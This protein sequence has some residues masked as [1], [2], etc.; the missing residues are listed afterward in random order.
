MYEL[1]VK[2]DKG[3]VINLTT[4]NKYTVYKIDGL[5]VPKVN[6]NKSGNATTDGSKI[7]SLKIDSRNLVIYMAIE[8]DV[9]NNR[10]NLYKYFPPKKTVTV[11]FS[12][13]SRDVMIEGV[14]ELIECDL[15]SQKQIA[16]ISIICPKPYFKGVEYLVTAFSD[17]DSLFSFPFAIE[18]EGIEISA[19]TP[20]VRKSII[21]TG[22]TE[23]GILIELFAL[24][25]VVNPILY[26]VLNSSHMALNFTMQTSDKIVINTNIGEKSITLI[27][28]G[29]STNALG[30]MSPDSEWFILENGDNVFTYDADS[31]K[32]NLQITFTTS[33]LYGGV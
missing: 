25:T 32:A 1:K 3:E 26:N 12:N 5:S 14:V 27:R 20:N 22:D 7:N 18:E 2:N 29:V 24:G 10:I 19:I 21:N 8:G 28:D 6:V 16:Q 13:D 9:E 30:Y 15:F 23:T 4:S 11:Y 31:G 17:I 33:L